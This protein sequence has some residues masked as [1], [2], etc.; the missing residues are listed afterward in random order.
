MVQSDVC[1][2]GGGGAGKTH[3]VRLKGEERGELI[4]TQW[5]A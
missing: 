5:L 4:I 2:G 3:S 1:G